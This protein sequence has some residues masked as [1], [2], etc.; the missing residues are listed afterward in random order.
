[1]PDCLVVHL[2]SVDYPDA[3]A[4]QRDLHHR[5]ATGDLPALLLLL[6]HP[7]VYT[8]GRRGNETD[9]L[10]SAEHPPRA[11]CRRASHRPRGGGDV[12]RTGA[13][14]RLSNTR[15]AGGRTRPSR[16][17]PR[18]G[19]GYHLDVGR[20]RHPRY[21]G[22]QAHR[23][24]GRRRQDRRHRRPR[25]SRCDDARVLLERN[26]DLSTST[27]SSRAG[28]PVQASHPSPSKVWAWRFLP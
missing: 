8:L 10:V 24:L 27:T 16:L 20:T 5:V 28:C 2:G 11:R 25:Q 26:P 4:L 15:P 22:R 23:R 19:T 18:T 14:C 6:Q 17:R 1:M 21:G 13:A 9:I 7:H 12:P 3:L